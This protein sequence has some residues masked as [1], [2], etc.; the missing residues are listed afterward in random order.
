MRVPRGHYIDHIQ[1]GTEALYF[2]DEIRMYVPAFWFNLYD[3]LSSHF[4]WSNLRKS[5][6]KTK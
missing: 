4:I 2:P 6:S 3:L 5:G 1:V